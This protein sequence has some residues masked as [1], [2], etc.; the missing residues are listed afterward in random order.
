VQISDCAVH[1]LSVHRYFHGLQTE[2]KPPKSLLLS[3]FSI[4]SPY[5]PTNC[6]IKTLRVLIFF[7]KTPLVSRSLLVT[8]GGR[9]AR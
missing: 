9:V 8:F 1:L 7:M 5:P 2:K 4:I 3:P 6:P